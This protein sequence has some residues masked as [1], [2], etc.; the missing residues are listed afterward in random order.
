MQY[1]YVHVKSLINTITRPDSL[2]NGSYTID[3]YQN[4]AFNC[5]YCDST[6]DPT[7]YIKSNAEEILKKKIKDLLKKRIIIGSVHDPYQHNHPIHII[8]KSDLI[9]RDLD[10]LKQMD[11]VLVTVSI[12]SLD[13]MICKLFEQDAP[14]SLKRLQTIKTLANNNIKT[15]TAMIPIFPFITDEMIEQVIQQSINHQASYF[16][17]DFLFS[18]VR[19]S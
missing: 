9:T 3:P 2:F 15:G 18:S 19:H 16:L 4:C 7:I 11:D 6:L 8:T 5:A 14:S 13:A 12:I 10:I 17:H 1:R